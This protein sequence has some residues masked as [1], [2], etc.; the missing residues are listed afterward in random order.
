MSLLE[1][2]VWKILECEN[3]ELEKKKLHELLIRSK[4]D[5]NIAVAKVRK[6]RKYYKLILGIE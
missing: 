3:C 1:N 5:L 6:N 2:E 4:M